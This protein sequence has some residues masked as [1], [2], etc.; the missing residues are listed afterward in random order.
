MTCAEGTEAIALAYRVPTG[1]NFITPV[2]RSQNSKAKFWKMKKCQQHRQAILIW[3]NGIRMM[4][5]DF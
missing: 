2:I 4:S 3:R 5:F 1:T